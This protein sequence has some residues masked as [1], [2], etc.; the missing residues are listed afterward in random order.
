MSKI[1]IG[2]VFI[3]SI[4]LAMFVPHTSS[5]AKES[6]GLHFENTDEPNKRAEELEKRLKQLEPPEPTQLN[7][8]TW[9]AEVEK[10]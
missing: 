4:L 1:R 6:V 2:Y 10:L 7:K 8:L 5:N 3:F 9:E